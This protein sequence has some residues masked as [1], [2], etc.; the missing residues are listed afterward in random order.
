MTSAS[1]SP[2]PSPAA[3]D[4]ALPGTTWNLAAGVSPVGA[5]ARREALDQLFRAFWRPPVEFLRRTFGVDAEEGLLLARAFLFDVA[6]GDSLREA[7]SGRVGFRAYLKILLRAAA[8]LGPGT[9][10]RSA[11]KAAGRL[12]RYDRM[13]APPRGFLEAAPALNPEQAFDWAWRKELLD[14]ALAK[15]RIMLQRTGREV[16]WRCFEEHDLAESE[17]R[18]SAG[19]VADRVGVPE[20]DVRNCLF[21]V[22]DRLRS[23]LRAEIAATVNDRARL[24][25]EWKELFGE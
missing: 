4:T 7:S 1:G 18:P 5:E 16:Q 24:D 23:E 6:E 25:E 11:G 17:R 19:E 2:S 21:M 22:R 14:R 10:R 20:G 13:E 15:V 3:A 8:A 9:L 12:P